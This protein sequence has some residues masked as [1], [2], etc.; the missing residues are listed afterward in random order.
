MTES[1]QIG[2]RNRENTARF[3]RAVLDADELKTL[4]LDR[5]TRPLV[6]L[7]L[8]HTNIAKQL[9]IITAYQNAWSDEP[10]CCVRQTCSMCPHRPNARAS[11][12]L[13]A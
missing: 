9:L 10:V 6:F 12:V 13:A 4:I 11:L 3:T 5:R 1:A 8:V 7:G 2:A